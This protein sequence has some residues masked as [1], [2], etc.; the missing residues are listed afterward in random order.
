MP[1]LT[2]LFKML[3]VAQGVARQELC[4][5]FEPACSPQLQVTITSTAERLRADAVVLN[6]CVSMAMTSTMFESIGQAM[7][8]VRR[9]IPKSKAAT[10][11][12]RMLALRKPRR[13]G[14]Q[15]PDIEL[16]MRPMSILSECANFRSVCSQRRMTSSAFFPLTMC[17]MEV[18]SRWRA[19]QWSVT[20]GRFNWII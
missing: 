2:S 19:M 20:L 10:L 7:N 14:E 17:S 12:T 8:G 11:H 6:N 1:T 9:L 3:A 5:I 16:A 18:R 4:S 13:T 15:L